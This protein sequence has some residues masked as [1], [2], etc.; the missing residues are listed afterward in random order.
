MDRVQK[1]NNHVHWY[2]CSVTLKVRRNTQHRS[3]LTVVSATSAPPFQHLRHQRTAAN[4]FTSDSNPLSTDSRKELTWS[5]VKVK[6][7]LW[8]TGSQSV[9]LGV[10]PQIFITVWQLRSWFVGCLLWRENGSVF[11]ICWWSLPAQSFSGLS[12]L[13][14]ATI[15][16][17]LRCKTSLFVASY[18]SQDHGGGIRPRL[19]TGSDLV[20]PTAFLTTPWHGPR[21]NTPFPT[22]LLLLLRERDYR[23]V[24]EK[25]SWYIRTSLVVA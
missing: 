20:T 13:G 6:V 10:E 14:L 16:Y 22:V 7:A 4:L 23:A 2:S 11:C 12:P 1:P 3:V 18:D 19:H 9:S 21:R 5:K 24:V 15:F 25:R 17:C 8:L